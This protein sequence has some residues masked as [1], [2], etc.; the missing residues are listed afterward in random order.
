MNLYVGTS[1]YSYKEWKGTFYPE[2]LPEKQ[3]LR[4]YGERFR[5]VEINNT[6]YRMPKATVLEGWAAEVPADFK[7]VLKAPQRITHIQ[8]LNEADD[9]VAYLLKVAAALKERLGP[10]L[11]QLPPYLKKDSQRLRNFLALLPQDPRSA[12][13]FRHPSWF[14]DEVFG[15]LRDHH[16]ALCIAEAEEGFEIPFVS[17]ADWGYLRLR[18]P[19][20]GDTDLKERVSRVRQQGWKDAFV[21]FKHEDEGKG[22]QMAKRFLELAA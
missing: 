7:F 11:F 22:P 18:R 9:S 19:D 17:T 4:F 1:G 13:E 2:D 21:F 16:A 12:F 15:L 10:L 20:Y 8:R 14:D 5:S 6:F 3:M